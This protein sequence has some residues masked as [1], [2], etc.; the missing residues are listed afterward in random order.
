MARRVPFYDPTVVIRYIEE[1]GG[2]ILTGFASIPD[3]QTVNADAAPYIN[4]ILE[5]VCK[6][7][8]CPLSLTLT[9]CPNPNVSL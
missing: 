7:R 2:V 6:Q 4:A 3:V 8:L 9:I 1:D 5:N